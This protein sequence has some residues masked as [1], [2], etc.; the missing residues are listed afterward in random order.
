MSAAQLPEWAEQMRQIFRAETIGQF[1]LYGNIN[2][3]VP[4]GE[5]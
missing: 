5:V 3:F 1:I 2:D 4:H